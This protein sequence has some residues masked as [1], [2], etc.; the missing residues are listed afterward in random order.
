MTATWWLSETLCYLR[1]LELA[2]RWHGAPGEPERW[3]LTDAGRGRSSAG[4]A[5]SAP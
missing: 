5:A 1:H 3:V 4:A 2:G